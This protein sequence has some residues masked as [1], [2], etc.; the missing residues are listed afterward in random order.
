MTHSDS[1]FMKSKKMDCYKII[2]HI[3]NG[4][5]KE[6]VKIENQADLFFEEVH[7]KGLKLCI[8]QL[9]GEW[10]SNDE[11][12][13]KMVCNHRKVTSRI[14]IKMLRET[15]TKLEIANLWLELVNYVNSIKKS[16]CLDNLD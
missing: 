13:F 2:E 4:N 8:N 11:S 16:K 14:Y 6:L 5:I 1:C 12:Y 3:K 10:S 7:R 9:K 15:Q